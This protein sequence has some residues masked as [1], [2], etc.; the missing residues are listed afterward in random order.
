[1]NLD[2]SS[3]TICPGLSS[4]ENIRRL[5]VAVN[6]L[7]KGS[8]VVRSPLELDPNDSLKG[9]FKT[10]TEVFPTAKND[11]FANYPIGHVGF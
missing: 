3:Q 9:F 5:Q 8:P 1:M 6:D 7:P 2:D 10:A 11:A 4:D